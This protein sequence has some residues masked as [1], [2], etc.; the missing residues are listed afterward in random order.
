M[1]E[2]VLAQN[3]TGANATCIN[4]PVRPP[5]DEFRFAVAIDVECH[6]ADGLIL[7][8]GNGKSAEFEIRFIQRLIHGCSRTF[9]AEKDRVAFLTFIRQRREPPF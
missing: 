6:Y 4:F 1:T 9:L 8:L 7:R 5:R 2:R 3:F